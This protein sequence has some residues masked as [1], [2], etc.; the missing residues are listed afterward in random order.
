MA[1]MKFPRKDEQVLDMPTIDASV[2][3]I[4]VEA[5]EDYIEGRP[6]APGKRLSLDYGRLLN[7]LP[8][9]VSAMAVLFFIA[10]LLLA[11]DVQ[12]SA[13]DAKYVEQSSQM[14][15]LSQRLAKDARE[16][17]YG[18]EDAFP[19]L[20]TSRNTFETIITAL[21]Q[22]DDKLDL[23]ASPSEVVFPLESLAKLWVQVRDNVDQILA[24]EQAML[25]MREHVVAINQL[26]P[27]LLA[28]SDEVVEAGTVAG[29][30]PE[31]LYLASR[32]GMLSQ[33]ISKDVNLFALGGSEAAVAAAQFGKDSKLFKETNARL[34]KV[35]PPTMRSKL[36]EVASAFT[37]M[38]GHISG[39]L[40]NAAELFVSQRASQLVF[41]QSD[42][43][44]Q[45]AEKLVQGYTMISEQR[46]TGTRLS[47]VIGFIGFLFMVLAGY[48]LYRDEHERA[49]E[50]AERN[51]STEESIL[52]LLDEMGDLADGDLTIQ[53]EVTEQIT[54]AIADSINFAVKEM[55]NLV[56]RIK[57]AASQVAVASERS[58]QTANELTQ[59]ATRQAA[60]IT[61]TTERMRDMARSMED[62]SISAGQS[63]E[64][65]KGSVDTAK[66]GAEAVR[67]TIKGMDEMREQI[68]ETAKRIKRL[69]E[70][71][72]QIGEI[73]ELINDVAE[74]TNIL[75][76]N[77]AIQAAMAG[78]AGRGFAVVADEVQRL[79]ERSA[80][81]TKQI[82]DLVKTIQA[83]TNEAVASMEQA[84]KGVVEGT[85]LADG[86]GRALT[87]IETVSE[88]LSGLIVDIARNA[89][90]HSEVATGV[91]NSMGQIQEATT[92]TSTGTHQTAEAIGRLSELARELQS[93]VAGFKLPA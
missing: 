52:K 67:T 56:V 79:A 49:R 47:Y 28:I 21:T 63:A 45:S 81:A 80:E 26:S 70:S 34:A 60:Q 91:S 72:Q 19:A 35:A 93:S 10:G 64:V 53:P 42:P 78:E 18:Q 44:L 48:K 24:Q 33:R 59:A 90:R 2:Q 37:E 77:A 32:Q 22:G 36:Q 9:L 30:R 58:R 69:G 83:D 11:L 5:G 61:E 84:T 13:R 54:G 4:A 27:L 6:P 29:M 43:L 85:R 76:L 23:P 15:M 20:K 88:R 46:E 65:A 73:V 66:R 39:I 50:S 3:E 31:Q 75:S 87:E 89:H 12:Q 68:Q 51:R 92:L 16:A 38:D 17:V 41:E 71:S 8:F 14:L 40:G 62:M 1:I 86:A 25:T 82:A 74:Q 7:N 55:R 57:N